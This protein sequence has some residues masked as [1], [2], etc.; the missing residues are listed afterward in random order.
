MKKKAEANTNCK[1][2][3]G[4]LSVVL[5][6]EFCSDECELKYLRQ[7][8]RRREESLKSAQEQMAPLECLGRVDWDICAQ[9]WYLKDSYDAKRRACVLRKLGFHCG[10]KSIGE[11]PVIGK[12]G[13]KMTRV[14]V[15]TIWGEGFVRPLPPWPPKIVQGLCRPKPKA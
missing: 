2:C 9:E 15:L 3:D 6:S 13:P 12:N 1:E 8:T 10:A 11:I 7:Q 14:T 4:P 5:G